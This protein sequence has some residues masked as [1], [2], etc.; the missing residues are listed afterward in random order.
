MSWFVKEGDDYAKSINELKRIVHN[1]QDN[2]SNEIGNDND[3]KEISS[4]TSD[5]LPYPSSRNPFKVGQYIVSGAHEEKVINVHGEIKGELR[6]RGTIK[7]EPTEEAPLTESFYRE[8]MKECDEVRRTKNPGYASSHDRGDQEECGLGS[9][10]T[11]KHDKR[12]TSGR[13]GG[14]HLTKQ[15][16]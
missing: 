3:N 1:Y 6:M 9:S 2:A 7:R 13:A 15:T 4:Y 8:V 12:K 5:T 16:T 11:G 10:K 14:G